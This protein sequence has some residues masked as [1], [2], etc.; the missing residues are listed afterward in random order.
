[1][2]KITLLIAVFIAV[3]ETVHAQNWQIEAQLS[4]SGITK[5]DVSPVTGTMFF[6]TSSIFYPTGSSAHIYRKILSSPLIVA[7]SPESGPLYIIRTV[8][9]DYRG[10]VWMSFWGDA[11]NTREKIYLSTN[12]GVSWVKKDSIE[13]S[14]NI[15]A[16]TVDSTTNFVYIATRNGVKRSTDG[17][18]IFTLYNNGFPQNQWARHLENI[19]NGVIFAS[20]FPGVYKSVNHG[21]SWALIPGMSSSDTAGAMCIERTPGTDGADSKLFCSAN[22]GSDL[23]GYTSDFGYAA[24][25]LTMAFTDITPSSVEPAS[26]NA[27]WLESSGDNPLAGRSCIFICAYPKLGGNGSI[28]YSTNGGSNWSQMNSGLTSP[29]TPSNIIYNKFNQK[30]YC[31]YFGNYQTGAKL[32]AM[33]FTVGVNQISSVVPD[34]FSLSQNYPNPFNPNTKIEFS[35]KNSSHIKIV[36]YNSAG[37]EVKVLANEVLS[38]GSYESELDASNFSSGVYFY[39]MFVDGKT[40]ANLSRKMVLVK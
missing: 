14:N 4:G 40:D 1:M 35:L 21:Q 3:F 7:T 25:F 36:V 22:S 15:F 23:K 39:R 28:V 17:G 33:N 19:G 31:G 29:I 38:A 37:K 2:K 11:N 8:Y 24:I 32:W 30:L 5:M 10:Y 12:D 26:V 13:T 9:C 18:N 6:A 27:Y 16:I 20:A 34:D